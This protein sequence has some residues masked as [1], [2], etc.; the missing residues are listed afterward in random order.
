MVNPSISAVAAEMGGFLGRRTPPVN[1][2]LE[3]LNQEVAE[4]EAKLRRAEHK[5]KMQRKI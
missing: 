1:E 5:E 3:K 4:T 2:K